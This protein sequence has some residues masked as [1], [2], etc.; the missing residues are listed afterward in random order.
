MKGILG[1]CDEEVTSLETFYIKVD[2]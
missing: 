2:W 1:Y